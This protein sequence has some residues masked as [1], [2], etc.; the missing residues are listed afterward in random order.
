MNRTLCI[1][2]ATLLALLCAT[3]C[4]AEGQ[5]GYYDPLPDIYE[6]VSPSVAVLEL[7]T[8]VWDAK[9]NT[10]TKTLV[11]ENKGL[12][13]ELDKLKVDHEKSIAQILESSSMATDERDRKIAAQDK[14]ISDLK[15]ELN[16]ERDLS[17]ALRAELQSLR[18]EKTK[19]DD[20]I[21]GMF[22][23]F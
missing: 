20:V 15:N 7:V 6:R 18:E 4:L 11:V 3:S 14:A 19:V 16:R 23:S 13:Q 10:V 1:A 2:L 21:F 12:R 5:T 22:P 9:T 17:Q 8:N